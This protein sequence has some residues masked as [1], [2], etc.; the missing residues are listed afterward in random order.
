MVERWTAVWGPAGLDEGPARAMTP[1]GSTRFELDA[2][3]IRRV[4]VRTT[5]D[6]DPGD[7]APGWWS[8]PGRAAAPGRRRGPHRR[9]RRPA[10]R[11]QRAGGLRGPGRRGG[12]AA[13]GRRHAADAAG[14]HR[15]RGAPGLESREGRRARSLAL[16]RLAA[17]VRQEPAAAAGLADAIRRRAAAGEPIDLLT[18]A[19]AS[20]NGVG[21]DALAGLLGDDLPEARSAM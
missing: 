19:L 4:S 20:A 14:G 15:R 11:L 13:R 12:S 10:G 1:G 3:G 2:Q 9:R 21:T 8:D 16:R 5:L 7:G 6:A 17:L 18:G